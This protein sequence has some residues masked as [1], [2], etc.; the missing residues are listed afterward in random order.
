MDADLGR[1]LYNSTLHGM[2]LV[3][4]LKTSERS[5][6]Y[7]LEDQQG[8]RYVHKHVLGDPS[9]YSRLAQQAAAGVIFD[10]LPS[11]CSV[12]PAPPGRDSG[13]DVLMDYVPGCALSALTAALG[14]LERAALAAYLVVPLAGA[15]AELESLNIVHRDVKPGNI[16]LT[17]ADEPCLTLVDFDIARTPKPGHFADTQVLGT[18]VYAPPE[19][20]GFGQTDARTDIYAAGMT[21]AAVLLGADPPTDLAAQQFSHPG[22]P[23][24]WQDFLQ[25]CCAFDPDGRF[26]DAQEM[27]GAIQ[28]DCML[29]ES[30]QLLTEDGPSWSELIAQAPSLAVP[31]TAP[32]TGV[33]TG[34]SEETADARAVDAAAGDKNTMATAAAAE[35]AAAV[36]AATGGAG[37]YRVDVLSAAPDAQDVRLTEPGAQVSRPKKLAFRG[38]RFTFISLLLLLLWAVWLCVV[39][40]AAATIASQSGLRD[41]LAFIVAFLGVSVC[42]LPLLSDR[43]MCTWI[44]RLPFPKTAARFAQA[45]LQHNVKWTG[46]VKLLLLAV[47]CFVAGAAL[48]GVINAVMGVSST[49]S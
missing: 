30:I 28:Y 12:M 34:A 1:F 41:T 6:T 9:E 27:L 13:F 4:Q 46:V 36:V 21:L 42:I 3:K 26:Q 31:D 48:L 22:I 37:P 33:D 47:L 44:A 11:V 29:R 24:A 7:L 16:V 14:P 45:R 18:A 49:T 35:A 20:L 23:V 5:R 19:Q 39:G 10:Y 15:L 17:P 38:M 32:D 43:W 2:R 25:G 8:Q 40:S